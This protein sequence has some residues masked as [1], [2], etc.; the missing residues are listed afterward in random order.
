MKLRKLIFAAVFTAVLT[1]VLT[2]VIS[3]VSAEGAEYPV[4]LSYSDGYAIMTAKTDDTEL[5]EGTLIAASIADGK[6]TKVR[7]YK[8][9][10]KIVYI[11]NDFGS[12]ETVKLMFWDGVSMKPMADSIETVIANQMEFGVFSRN[13]EVLDSHGKKILAPLIF[14]NGEQSY[15]VCRDGVNAGDLGLSMGD[16]IMY[17]LNPDQEIIEVKKLF[18]DGVDLTDTESLWTMAKADSAAMIDREYVQGLKEGNEETDL[19]FGAVCDKFRQGFCVTDIKDNISDVEYGATEIGLFGDVNIYKI[20]YNENPNNR[21]S[22]SSFAN[23][24]KTSIRSEAWVD[25]ERTKVDW[26]K[27]IRTNPYLALV[28][29]VDRDALDVVIIKPKLD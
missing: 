11:N 10:S 27:N 1:T 15:F 14:T 2:A 4:S 24:A 12:G 17:A 28:R 19:Y 13:I 8:N 22:I 16:V 7:T 3:S 23:I 29:G 9:I 6:I 21:I 25:D 18:K 26:S 5:H 20:D